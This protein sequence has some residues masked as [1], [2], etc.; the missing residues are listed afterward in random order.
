MVGFFYYVT[1]VHVSLKLESFN[2]GNEKRE[3]F[4]LLNSY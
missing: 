3:L 2:P 1:G 4:A